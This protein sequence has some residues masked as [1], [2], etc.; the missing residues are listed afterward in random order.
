MTASMLGPEEGETFWFLGSLATIKAGGAAT[1]DRLTVVE[2]LNP[3]GFAPPLHRHLHED[4]LFYV[5]EGAAEFHCE[6]Q[7]LKAQPGHFVLLPAGKPHT[8]K[9]GT[10]P[11]RALQITSPSGF[12]S[13]IKA[14]GTPAPSHH[15]PSP[16]TAA[17]IDPAALGHAAALHDIE[18]LGPPPM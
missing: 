13:F 9:V 17:P 5:L 11:L 14:A 1:H 8:F 10:E 15:L 6:N 18:I 16:D 12:A 7:V 2:F 4:E 3:P